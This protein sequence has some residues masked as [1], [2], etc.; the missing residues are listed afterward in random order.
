MM[1]RIQDVET[2]TKIEGGLTYEEAKEELALFEKMDIEEGIYKPDF[3][4][5]VEEG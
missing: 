1:Y 2:G 5:I 4:E 3:Y